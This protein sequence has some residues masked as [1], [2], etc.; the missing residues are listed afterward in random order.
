MKKIS[1]LLIF[2]SSSLFVFSADYNVASPDGRLQL[3]ISSGAQLTYQILL[4]QQAISAK[5]GIGMTI[6]GK[7]KI[8]ENAEVNSVTRSSADSTI[9]VLFG[10]N[11]EIED[12][13]NEMTLNL[14]DY[15]LIC[16][17]YNEGVAYRFETKYR[18]GIIVENELA[19][20]DFPETPTI[21]L[22]YEEPPHTM[23]H[24]ELLY[25]KLNSIDE[26]RAND[27]AITPIMFKNES[28]GL[29]ITVAES[30]L[31]EYPGL[32]VLHQNTDKKLVGKFAG[33]PDQI[34]NTSIYDSQKVLSRLDYIANT[35]GARQF[36]WRCFII[37][38]DDK[39]LLNNNLIYK[40]ASPL[41]LDDIS[42]IKPG[43]TAWDWLHD[44]ELEGVNFPAGPGIPRTL[45][46][47]KYY[48]DFAAEKGLE[49]MTLDA[50]WN[51]SY[52]QELCQ[53]AASKNVKIF[54][55]TYFNFVVKNE[56]MLDDFKNW[57][58]SGVKVDFIA[59]DDQ[60]ATGWL[61]SMAKACAKRQLMIIM[62]G[63]PKPTGLQRAY[64]N[65]LN[66]EGV[67]GEEHSK[68][69]DD[70]SPIY[71]TVYPFLRLLGGP[72][73]ITP[74]SLRN[75]TKLKFTVD[76][77][78][79]PN[80]L[81]TRTQQMAMYVINNQPLGFV[82]DAPTEYKKYPEVTNLICG[83][84]SVWDET[85]PLKAE[86]GE[87]LITARRSGNIWYVGGITNWTERKGM[88]ISFSFLPVGT[89]YEAYIMKDVPTVNNDKGFRTGDAT[90]CQFETINVDSQSIL[91]VDFAQGGGVLIRLRPVST[92]SVE[93]T[94][95][96]ITSIWYDNEN[97]LIHFNNDADNSIYILYDIAGRK[98]KTC[99]ALIGYNTISASDLINGNY[100]LSSR[101]KNKKGKIIIY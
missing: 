33:F 35:K 47:Y 36:P 2:I 23:S 13:C 16:R 88:E 48:V 83:I 54:V 31:I 84:P 57:G 43:K 34:E 8:G 100:I 1:L 77:V 87:Y 81:G 38:H 99:N 72:A 41:A 89:T 73:D 19:E 98:V 80:S 51:S 17:A 55:W 90:A 78:G 53:Y 18:G 97:R 63:S 6:R 71:R 66:Y 24:W 44:G 74:G 39:E 20:F 96:N 40:L 95:D 3:K 45:E 25:S 29:G 30:D 76:D 50:G 42:W 15:N 69:N 60:V 70:C 93:T 32:Y 101:G 22:A 65:I 59:R 58:I 62:H 52:I 49:Y 67:I 37:T 21:H 56:S 27:Y 4:D 46:F 26:F 5:C 14:G 7:A 10:T 91:N 79:A 86:I 12:R 28:T 11:K 92:N 94:N 85:K 64:P 9:T 61:T 68:W 75:T 82:S